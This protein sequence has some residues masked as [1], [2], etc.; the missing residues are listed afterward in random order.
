MIV[1]LIQASTPCCKN[2]PSAIHKGKAGNYDIESKKLVVCPPN[3]DIDIDSDDSEEAEPAYDEKKRCAAARRGL[4]L[5]PSASITSPS[6]S[7][8]HSRNSSRESSTPHTKIIYVTTGG[9]QNREAILRAKTTIE[10]QI[11]HLQEDILRWRRL[12][13]N[14]PSQAKHLHQDLYQDEI[15]ES[16]GILTVLWSFWRRL[17]MEERKAQQ[18]LSSSYWSDSMK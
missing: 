13:Q 3:S 14:F 8:T 16:E 15:L 6:A 10:D 9:Q 12:Q 4:I 17:V 1:Q 5:E 18:P 7:L 11:I 2:C